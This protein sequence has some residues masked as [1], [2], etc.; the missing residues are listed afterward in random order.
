M[1][2]K[3]LGFT[4]IELLVVTGLMMMLLLGVSTLFVAS[5]TNSA[6][7][8]LRQEMRAEGTYALDVISHAIRNAVF[9]EPSSCISNGSSL[10]ISNPDGFL[11][12]FR[13]QSG[14]IASNSSPLTSTQYSVTNFV[15]DCNPNTP[16]NP[17]YVVISFTLNRIDS[18]NTPIVTEFR[19]AV[20][21]RNR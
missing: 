17:P 4:L 2:R 7:M 9:I 20:L 11:T 6:K 21:V 12:N 3:N 15:L 10:Q 18:T 14:R 13:L 8:T 5:L 1:A 19:R 16:P